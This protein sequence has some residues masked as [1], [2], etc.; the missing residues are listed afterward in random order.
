MLCSTLSALESEVLSPKANWKKVTYNEEGFSIEIPMIPT[1]QKIDSNAE[2]EK[3]NFGPIVMDNGYIQIVVVNVKDPLKSYELFKKFQKDTG[4][5]ED[6]YK[7]IQYEGREAYLNTYLNQNPKNPKEIRKQLEFFTE[8][9]GTLYSIGYIDN[10]S[11][12]SEKSKTEFDKIVKSF[13]FEPQSKKITSFLNDGFIIYNFP[14]MVSDKKTEKSNENSTT[15]Y[16]GFLNGGPFRIAIIEPVNKS[17]INQQ[18]TFYKI[19]S[20]VVKKIKN[21][22]EMIVSHEG[23]PASFGDRNDEKHADGYIG[24]SFTTLRNGKIYVISHMFFGSDKE[25]ANIKFKEFIDAIIFL[26]N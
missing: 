10:G 24:L 8:N 1:K 14:I 19:L 7:K 3:I 11:E 22:E 26:D 21:I 17:L 2:Y 4:L 9:Y 16:T 23:Y 20:G 6:Q 18:V 13:H 5:K 15:T 25:V 12:I